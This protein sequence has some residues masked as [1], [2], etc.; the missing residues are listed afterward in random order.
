MPKASTFGSLISSQVIDSDSVPLITNAGDNKRVPISEFRDV[1]GL[2]WGLTI[3]AA[4]FPG[5]DDEEKITAAIVFAAGI[6]APR[7]FVPTSML[8]YDATA[9]AFNTLVQMVR[10]GGNFDVYDWR[11]YGAAGNDSNDDFDAIDAARDGAVAGGGVLYGPPGIYQHSQMVDFSGVPVVRGAGRTETILK[12]TSAFGSLTTCVRIEADQYVE[13][14][15]VDGSLTTTDCIGVHLAETGLSTDIKLR[16]V[17]IVSFDST[18]AVGLRINNLV[19]GMIESCFISA[20]YVDVDILSD[21]GSLP[22]Q[23]KFFDTTIRSAVASGVRIREGYALS[24]IGCVI[25]ANGQEGVRAAPSGVNVSLVHFF[26][27]WFEGNYSSNPSFFGV[28][29][30]GSAGGVGSLRV[31]HCYFNG[32][33]ATEK[34]LN[35]IDVGD[36]V[37]DDIHVFARTAN[38]QIDGASTG[39]IDNWPGAN[40][41]QSTTVDDNSGGGVWTHRAHIEAIEGVWTSYTPTYSAS[42]SMTFTSV[43]TQLARYKVVGKTVT[44]THTFIGTTGGSAGQSIKATLPTFV[45]SQSAVPFYCAM[46]SQD[47][48]ST[49]SFAIAQPDA[50]GPPSVVNYY[51]SNLANW[52]LGAGRA[53]SATFTFE[54]A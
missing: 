18:N 6:S 40:G 44:V 28:T 31:T 52:G 49:Y 35:L 39:Y 7:V 8:P 46:V 33:A 12:P 42:G 17:G 23:V 22:T 24:F 16:R 41:S 29:F 48:G 4:R 9:V 14:L 43:T 13:D 30:D 50:E 27:C 25:E 32:S 38:I 3:N 21:L 51:L 20:N 2:G 11:A 5:I 15:Q 10:E 47:G 54:M 1:V 34:A 26:D 53:V 19:G 37:L 36:F 45:D